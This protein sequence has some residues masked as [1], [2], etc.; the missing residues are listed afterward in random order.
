MVDR[1]R[2]YEYKHVEV[3][4]LPQVV[5]LVTNDHSK[6][7][8][9]LT[10]TQTVVAKESHLESGEYNPDNL[11]SVTTT[12]RFVALDFK[13]PTDVPN[14]PKIKQVE[15]EY[16]QICAALRNVGASPLDGYAPPPTESLSFAD[17]MGISALTAMANPGYL[18]WILTWGPIRE[19]KRVGIAGLLFPAFAY[20]KKSQAAVIEEYG[21]I[22]PRLDAL[23]RDNKGILNITA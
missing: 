5:N 15:D 8:W 4:Q 22:K 19:I 1:P 6:F 7:Y 10:A 9:E 16:Y 2:G 3:P 14:L 12:E 23:L 11:Y 17:L 20:R 18:L 21:R 13:R